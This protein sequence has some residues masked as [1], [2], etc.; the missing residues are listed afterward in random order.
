VAALPPFPAPDADG[1]YPAKEYMAASLS[2]KIVKG[3]VEA[4]LTQR[5][6]AELA[7]ITFE[8]LN[9]LESGRITP[10]LATMMKIEGALKRASAANAKRTK[11]K[12]RVTG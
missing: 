1:N 2:R 4:G 10:T 5:A 3:C 9:R 8:H 11:R 6:L 7:G 12:S